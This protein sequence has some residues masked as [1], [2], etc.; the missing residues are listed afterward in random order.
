MLENILEG[1]REGRSE[2]MDFKG[3]G[4]MMFDGE[5]KGRGLE[6]PKQAV[7]EGVKVVRRELEK[8]C[9][10]EGEDEDE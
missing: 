9:V 3:K 1:V 2:I 8:V 10:V 4:K 6:V 5:G 7:E